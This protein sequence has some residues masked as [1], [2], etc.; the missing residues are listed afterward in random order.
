MEGYFL[1]KPVSPWL[2][3]RGP[4]N[5]KHDEQILPLLQDYK[6][7]AMRGK[8]NLFTLAHLMGSHIDYKDRYP[9]PFGVFKSED[10]HPIEPHLLSKEAEKSAHYINSVLYNDW[11]VSEIIRYYSHTSSIVIYMSDHAVARYDDPLEPHSTAHSMTQHSLSIPFMVYMSD[12]FMAENPDIVK[13]VK[14]ACH[15]PFMTDFFTNSLLSL[16]GIQVPY[17]SPQ[18]E[19]WSAQYDASRPRE[20][21]EWGEEVAFEPKYP[22]QLQ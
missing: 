16:M 9:E 12:Q 14:G 8:T 7:I 15:R 3:D 11:I 19:L 1:G 20:V 5:K 18:I 13:L 10:I 22:N 6:T 4:K 21:H 17:S 2:W